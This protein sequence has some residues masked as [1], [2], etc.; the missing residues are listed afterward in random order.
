LF[1]TGTNVVVNTHGGKL[2]SDYHAIF[3]RF[4]RIAGRRWP[5]D[6]WQEPADQGEVI[7]SESLYIDGK[8]EGAITLPDSRVTVSR[9]KQVSANIT[10]REVVVFSKVSGNINASDRVD[11]RSEGSTGDMSAQRITIG[12]SA[13]LKGSMDNQ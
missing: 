8:V 4:R 13:F 6:D 10:A 11:I 2:W 3:L 12:D 7:G 9:N 1:K 5:T